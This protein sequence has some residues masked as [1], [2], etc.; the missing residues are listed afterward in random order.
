RFHRPITTTIAEVIGVMG[1]LIE[2]AWRDGELPQETG[3]GGE[4]RRA[5]S[6]F[7][8]R[9]TADGSSGIKAQARRYH[10]SVASC[11]PLAHLTLIYRSIKEL[12][13]AITVDYAIPGL[14]QQGW[15][16]DNDPAFPDCTPDRVNGFRYLHQAYTATDQRYTGKVTVPT[17]W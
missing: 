3:T 7:R 4:F 10:L 17:L 6:R 13:G 5:D 8:D 16:F 1:V 11:W 15:M 2:G 9:I 14:K 12:E